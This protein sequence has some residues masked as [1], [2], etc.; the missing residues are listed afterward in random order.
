MTWTKAAALCTRQTALTGD[1]WTLQPDG[2]GWQVV[3]LGPYSGAPSGTPAAAIYFKDSYRI[4]IDGVTIAEVRKIDI[5]Q[6]EA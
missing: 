1:H 3:N 4:T 2:D 5:N 6:E